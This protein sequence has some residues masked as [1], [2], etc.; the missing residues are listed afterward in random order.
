MSL[1]EPVDFTILQLGA[2]RIDSPVHTTEF[3]SDDERVLY[4]VFRQGV[5]PY[6]ERGEELPGFEMA[7]P[8][9]LIY[10]DPSKVKAAIISCG[11]L[12][13]GINDVIRA[14][15]MC[16][17]YRY[18]VRNILGIRYGY[19]G[20][21]PSYGH[22]VWE[23]DPKMVAHIHT[24][25]G[26]FLSSS[27]GEQDIGVMVD[28]LERMNINILFCIGGDGTLRG[29][30]RIHEEITSR[31]LKISVIGLP[32]TIDNDM[33]YIEKTFGYETAFSVGIDA[34]RSAHS[35]AEGAPNGIGL[36]KLM[37]RHSGYLAASAALALNDA[38]FVLVPEVPFD[39]DG[40]NG[41]LEVLRARLARRHHAV[42]LVAEGAGQEFFHAEQRH[43]ASGNVR[44]NDIGIFLKSRINQYFR[45][46][47]ME[48]NLKYIDPSYIVRSTPANA[49]DSIYCLLLAFNAVHAAMAGKT[50]MVVGKWNNI[51][52]HVPISP[53]VS[54][55]N[56]ISPD[57]TLW[58]SVLEVTGQPPSMVNDQGQ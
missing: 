28:A 19:Q 47:G 40:P 31:R 57:G 17:H 27:R 15:V 3:V 30:H 24:S 50:D 32:K 45:G 58:Q 54:R 39:L 33:C 51:F 23:L 14:L 7:G 12:C 29:A 26:S 6:L 46:I 16:L 20:L 25:G 21:V 22:D 18:G 43:D 8:R 1:I 55:R 11:G 34:I 53:V 10:F 13:P 37:G 42:I 36:V 52:T 5:R 56:S 38:N 49:S 4:N 41:L 48:A 2:C 44:L 35:E 9:R